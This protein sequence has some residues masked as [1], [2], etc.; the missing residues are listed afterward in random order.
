[1]KK[2]TIEI[3]GL[4]LS[5]PQDPYKG[6]FEKIH[7]GPQHSGLVRIKYASGMGVETFQSYLTKL[8]C[9]SKKSEK[10]IY[11]KMKVE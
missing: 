9:D 8:N 1:M 11:D 4:F 7:K 2:G 5:I 3:S 6:C 10:K